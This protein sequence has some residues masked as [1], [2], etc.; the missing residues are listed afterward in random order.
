MVEPQVEKHFGSGTPGDTRGQMIAKRYISKAK[1]YKA[2]YGTTSIAI[3]MCCIIAHT[4]VFAL[5]LKPVVPQGLREGASSF[6]E[7]NLQS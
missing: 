2:P 6:K 5:L 7:T 1:E 3:A 4:F